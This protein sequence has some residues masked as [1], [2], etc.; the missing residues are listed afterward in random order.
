MKI[1]LLHYNC[2]GSKQLLKKNEFLPLAYPILK[3]VRI[4]EETWVRLFSSSCLGKITE[5]EGERELEIY[6]TYSHPSLQQFL[7]SL[8]YLFGLNPIY[9]KVQGKGYEVVKNIEQDQDVHG[10][11][12][13]GHICQ[14]HNQQ[15]GAE[16]EDEDEVGATRAQSLDCISLSLELEHSS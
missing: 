12:L 9:N 2:P 6:F 5:K 11:A 16:E 14:H 3:Q 7:N 8:F 1:K 4:K 10:D 13:S 15:D